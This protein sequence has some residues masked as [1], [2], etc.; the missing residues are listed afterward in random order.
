MAATI[1]PFAEAMLSRLHISYRKIPVRNGTIYFCSIPNKCTF[2]LLI[3]DTGEIKLWSFIGECSPSKA[4]ICYEYRNS[5]QP[6]AAIGVEI[7]RDGDISFYA[8]SAFEE[9]FFLHEN[10]IQHFF[11]WYTT[12]IS[13]LGNRK[14]E[15]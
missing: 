14:I 3:N 1:A 10:R 12:Q 13:N 5:K 15:M 11:D 4:G 9:G 8:E 7:T 2:D 6:N